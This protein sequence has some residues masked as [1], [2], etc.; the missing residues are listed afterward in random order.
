MKIK[1]IKA[2]TKKE[3]KH[4]FRDY[5]LLGILLFFPMFLLGAF[6]Y[7]VNFDVENVRL[8]IVDK[9]GTPTS[10]DFARTATASRTFEAVA[11]PKTEAAAR[12]ILDRGE[13]HAVVVIPNDFAE[14]LGAGEEAPTQF[15]IDGVDAN[16][17]KIVKNYLLAVAAR[18]N[19]ERTERTLAKYGK[20]YATPL[21]F[22]PRFWYNPELETTKYLVPGLIAMILII[23][24]CV[25]VSLTLVRERERGTM[26]QIN[27]SPIQTVELMLGKTIPYTVVALGASAFTLLVAYLL[28]DVGVAGSYLWLFVSTLLFLASSTALGVLVSTVSDSQQVAF[29]LGTFVSLLPSLILSGFVFQIE[30]MPVVIQ[31][32]TNLTPAK[33]YLESLRAI[34]LRGVGIEAFREQL[35]YLTA[36]TVALLAAASGIRAAKEKRA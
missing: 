27:V 19:A 32:A 4:L 10:R 30:S 33:F 18:F 7:A 9:D 12:A 3:F 31:W 11:Y 6:G 15:L 13:A 24:A 21:D 16:T 28:F 35:I 23:T 36:F 14:R 26:E 22:R 5:R 17:A 1:R 25:S 8:A 29:T 2:L 34:M 20:S